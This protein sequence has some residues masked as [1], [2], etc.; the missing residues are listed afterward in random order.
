MLAVTV[1]LSASASAAALVFGLFV[2]FPRE[3][4]RSVIQ[5]SLTEVEKRATTVAD[6]ACVVVRAAERGG[7]HPCTANPL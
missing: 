2:F 6:F 4:C 5:Y 7:R 1:S 3:S